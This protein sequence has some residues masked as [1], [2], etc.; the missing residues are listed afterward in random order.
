MSNKNVFYVFCSLCFVYVIPSLISGFY[1]NDDMFRSVIGYYGWN[2]DGRPLSDYVYKFIS[3]K[4][5]LPDYFPLPIA[6]SLVAYSYISIRIAKNIFHIQSYAAIFIALSIITNPFFASNLWYRYDS[7]F[8]VMSVCMAIAPFSFNKERTIVWVVSTFLLLMS[9]SLYQASI[10]LFIII[11]SIEM[12]ISFSKNILSTKNILLRLLRRFL[13]FLFSII[14]Y[15][16]IVMPLTDTGYYFNDFNK[17]I[18]PSLDGLHKLI[19]NYKNAYSYMWEIT[20][21]PLLYP[22]LLAMIIFI[23]SCVSLFFKSHRRIEFTISML[24][25]M[26]MSILFSPGVSMFSEN[27][28]FMPRVYIGFGGFILFITSIIVIS[29][30]DCNTSKNIKRIS[31]CVLVYFYFSIFAFFY[32]ATNANNE[33]FNNKTALANRIVSVLDTLNLSNSN[34]LFF[35]GEPPKSHAVQINKLVYPF[36]EVMVLT[37]FSSGYDGGRFM[38]MRAGMRDIEYPSNEVRQM[39]LSL[40]KDSIPVFK[41]NVFSVYRIDNVTL[42]KF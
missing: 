31:Y 14:I 32:S 34:V 37:T 30:S 6:L 29:F 39:I 9:L 15:F 25:T 7:F 36:S 12:T 4:P 17:I 42:I 20:N 10:A 22:I 33:E 27:P 35:D 21:S 2:G 40:S 38:L 18:H 19:E 41:N 26:L 16:K 1:Y 13:S 3:T 8:M 24:I 28:S 5:V 23:V 11:S